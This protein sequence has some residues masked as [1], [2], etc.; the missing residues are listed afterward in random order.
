MYEHERVNAKKKKKKLALSIRD[1][2]MII[3]LATYLCSFIGIIQEVSDSCWF[4]HFAQ[5]NRGF[6]ICLPNGN[7]MS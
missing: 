6:L 2:T 5:G 4:R 1:D 3:T 7:C